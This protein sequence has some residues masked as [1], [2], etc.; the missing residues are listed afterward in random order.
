LSR[1][2][3]HGRRHHTAL[4]E[5]VDCRFAP[6][7]QPFSHIIYRMIKTIVA[8]FLILI[9]GASRAQ[10]QEAARSASE[11]GAVA[12]YGDR[13]WLLDID[14][15]EVRGLFYKI[16]GLDVEVSITR[17]GPL[18]WHESE[19]RRI[20]RRVDD[21]VWNGARNGFIVGGAL[22][23]IQGLYLRKTHI[24]GIVPLSIAVH[25]ALCMP[26]GAGVDAL[27]T[28]QQVIFERPHEP[29][30]VDETTPFAMQSPAP[31]KP[32]GFTLRF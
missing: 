13:I 21:S 9:V 12:R 32:S 16:S 20:R 3:A 10:A 24:R 22:G 31:A 25:G 2:A 5:I 7:A 27:M 15:R 8:A 17:S 26:F 28:R 19:I 11:L 6:G 4:R 23:L 29:V 30:T 14:G 18:R 1:V